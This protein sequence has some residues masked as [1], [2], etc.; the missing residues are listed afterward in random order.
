MSLRPALQDTRP[1]RVPGRKIRVL[2]VDDSALA[3]KLITDT[4]EEAGDIEV[5]GCAADGYAACEKVATLRPDVLTL[6]IGM[7]GMDGLTF[8]RKAKALNWGPAVVVSAITTAGCQTALEALRAGAVEVISKP[9]D[10]AAFLDFRAVLPAKVRAAFACRQKV[11]AKPPAIGGASA[12]KLR[13]P[14]LIAIG[15]STGGTE[16]VET[17]LRQ[18]PA[19]C[20]GIVIAQHIPARF[21]LMFA[22]R[23]SQ[24]CAIK[25][26]EAVSGDVIRT[27][28][29]L[30]APGDQ[31]MTVRKCAGGFEAMVNQGP[32][33][34]FQRPSV[35]MLFHSVAA[36]V[37]GDAIGAI[38]TGMGN[39]G[40]AG[41]LAMKQAR[42]VTIA[43]DEA[44]C[45]VFGMPKEAIKAGA[46]DHV[47]PLN[48]IAATLGCLHG[49]RTIT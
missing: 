24:V 35:D 11:Q 14:A 12:L 39:D 42:A 22:E 30:I 41:L 6:D 4:L 17:I 28:L 46:V 26:K 29:A 5:A 23:L 25:V 9:V 44:S 33:V 21:S 32:R 37:A 7:P 13:V 20:P 45:A 27:G 1:A 19:D 15:S 8:L 49:R 31:H 47:L 18:M 34:G 3:R 2:V 10:K 40:A 48:Q 16:A 43:Q 36:A 38:L